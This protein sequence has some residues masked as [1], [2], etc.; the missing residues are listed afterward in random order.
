[1]KNLNTL[2]DDIYHLFAP[3]N[4]HEVNEENVTWFMEEMGTLMRTRFQE[5]QR[6]DTLRFSNLGYPDRKLWYSCQGTEGEA[7]TPKTYFKFLYGD[8][9]ELL[10]LFLA[11]EAGHE[12][13][14]LQHEVELD[15]VKGHLDAVIDGTVVDVKSA[16]P[17]GYQKFK[18]GK[19]LEDDIFGYGMQLAGYSQ[20]INGPDKPAAWVAFNKIDGDICVSTMGSGVIGSEKYNVENRIKHLKSVV[21]SPEPPERCFAEVPEGKSGNM[22]LSTGCSYCPYKFQCWPGVRTFLYSNGPKYLTK[23]VNTPKVFE[24]TNEV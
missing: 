1:M 4:P 10:V 17:Y 15:G 14:H 18:T 20:V 6:S 16:A 23:V 19:V 3:D 13:T 22:A 5:R 24:L 9:I 2:V 12:V 7:L 21:E 11:K 8:V